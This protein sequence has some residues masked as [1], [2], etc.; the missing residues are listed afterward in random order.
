MPENLRA[1]FPFFSANPGIV[2]LDSGATALK[3]QRVV[4]AL[5]EYTA[6]ESVNIHRG[7]YR[8]SQRAT[9]TVED[10]QGAHKLLR[11]SQHD[12]GRHWRSSPKAPPKVLTCSRMR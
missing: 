3:P 11:L 5:V 9:D 2:Y 8:L 6:R 10:R 12:A 7:V 1:E 4:D